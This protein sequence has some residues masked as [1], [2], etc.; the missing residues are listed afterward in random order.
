MRGSEF[1]GFAG[2]DCEVFWSTGVL[3]HWSVGKSESLNFNLNASFHYS[4]TPPLHHSNSYGK[5]V[6]AGLP[7]LAAMILLVG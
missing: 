6:E 4:I 2:K 7:V 3:E 1:N 5:D